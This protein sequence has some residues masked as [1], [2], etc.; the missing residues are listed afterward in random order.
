M[1]SSV[2]M[3]APATGYLTSMDSTAAPVLVAGAS[4][5]V[6]ARL[7][8]AL[9]DAGRP[10]RA[11]TR[12]PG[13]YPGVG[14]PVYGDVHDPASLCAA[15]A[16]CDAA[17]YLVHS[18]D[19]AD[20]TRR[21]AAAAAAFGLAAADAGLRRIVYLGGLGD[22]S[23]QLSAHLRSRREMERLLGAGGVP[24][25]TL[26]AGIVL[27]TGGIS[28][29][30]TRQLVDRVPAMLAPSWVRTLT[31]PIALDDAVRYLVGVLDLPATAGEAF[32]IGGPEVLS[33][34]DL[35]HRVAAIMGRSTLVLP[36]PLL[37]RLL[38]PPLS[39]L[40]L[41]PHWV[42]LGLALATDVDVPTGRALLSSMNN[43]M[44]MREHRIRTLVPF[45]PMDFDHAVLAALGGPSSRRIA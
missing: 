13:S 18:L 39:W 34:A 33:Y 45:E 20:F 14:C 23:D 30:L 32:D 12:R 40:W 10:V 1:R 26:R 5:F 35:V 8:S 6:G 7:C 21:D 25:T 4:G 16:G 11:M 37:G 36:V 3:A 38:S 43:E 24:V 31:Q 9:C 22:D 15:L 28:W 29:E 19:D 17:Y 42:T 2:R 44:V 27:G 41:A